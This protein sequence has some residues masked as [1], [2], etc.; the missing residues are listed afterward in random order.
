MLVVGAG[1][2]AKELLMVISQMNLKEE[3]AFY[4]DIT[5]NCSDYLYSK[6]PI[7]KNEKQAI[8]FLKKNNFNFTIGI[9]N[10]ILRKKMYKKFLLLNG[11]FTSTICNNIIVGSEDVKISDGTNVL[12]GTKISNSVSIGMG[13]LIY[14]NVVLTHNV[15]TK[16]FVEISPNAIILG[17]VT[18]GEFSHIGSNATILPNVMIGKNVIVGAGS[19]VTKDIPDNEVWIGNPAR[20]Y[21]MNKILDL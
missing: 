18:I 19:V 13:N 5:P 7:L 17:H 16:D 3:I 4:D 20:F 14:Y 21:K 1:G 11:N 2:L 8:S 15:T 10:P 12:A 9:G 6:Y